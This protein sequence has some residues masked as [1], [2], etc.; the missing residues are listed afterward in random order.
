MIFLNVLTSGEMYAEELNAAYLGV[1]EL[2]LM[3]NAGA[4]VA[5]EVASRFTV[6][7]CRVVVYAGT[8][9]NGGD[10]F[11]AARHLA[12]H[13]FK[14]KVVLVGRVKDVVRE[15]SKVNLNALLRM[16]D[17][18]EFVEAYDSSMFKAED[19]DVLIDAILGY[20]VKGVLKPPILQAVRTFNESKGFKIA[21]DIPTGLDADTGEVLGEAVKAD[22]T[23]TFHKPKKGLLNNPGFVGELKVVNI[24]IPPE[25][26][27]YAGPGDVFLAVKPRPPQSHKGDF[28]RLLVVG[29][30]E[31]YTGAPALTAMAALRAGVDLVFIAAPE[32]TAY[33]ISG[34][35][36]NLITVKLEGEY[37]KPEHFEKLKPLID[38]STGL[39]IGPGLG[40][41]DE[42]FQAFK[43]IVDYAWSKN[44]PTVIDADGLK[45]YAVYRLKAGYAT[46][47]TPHL[48]E[49]SLIF[50]QPPKE[51]EKLKLHVRENAARIGLTILLK[52]MVDIVSDGIRVKL[53]F[54]GNPGMTV[55]GTGDV[56]TGIVAT[57][58]SQ[59]V[60]P[61][62]AATAAAFINGL[63]GDIVAS[64]IGYHM[65]ASDLL[66]VIPEAIELCMKG[67]VG[68][69]EELYYLKARRVGV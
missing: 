42:T 64:K 37:L 2:Q 17:S 53:N 10:G 48:G 6:E 4:A 59:G 46:V 29:G 3:E 1:S 19:A 43:L 61:F 14:V 18:V 67:D 38:K 60:E 28:G 40:L 47:L 31:T 58:L 36:P 20:G 55:G 33:T 49:Y 54:T 69:L 66:D 35:S 32:K 15:S 34:F 26:S 39:A 57:F 21:V 16:R 52:G 51:F 23:L 62:K 41:R 8:G 63:A 68:R 44:I 12:Y 13:G 27:M 56:L 30:C 5:R 11:V 7:N 45:A 24:G 9:G 50:G 25:A 65:T 22:L